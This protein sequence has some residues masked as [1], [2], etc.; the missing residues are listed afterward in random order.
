MTESLAIDSDLRE[1]VTVEVLDETF[2]DGQEATKDGPDK[3]AVANHC[4][5]GF[6]ERNEQGAKTDGTERSGH[7]SLEGGQRGVCGHASR[8]QEIPRGEDSSGGDVN[9]VLDDLSGPV[10][11]EQKVRDHQP[12]PLAGENKNREEESS[13]P[14]ERPKDHGKQ[15]SHRD[16]DGVGELV[17]N[18]SDALKDVLRE[19]DSVAP[20]VEEEH[21]DGG[22]DQKDNAGSNGPGNEPNDGRDDVATKSEAEGE[23]HNHAGKL[24]EQEDPEGGEQRPEDG[25][26]N[27][28]HDERPHGRFRTSTASSALGLLQLAIGVVVSIDRAQALEFS[29][30]HSEKDNRHQEMSE[31]EDQ[32]VDVTILSKC[33]ESFLFGSSASR[34][35]GDAFIELSGSVEAVGLFLELCHIAGLLL[36]RLAIGWLGLP[37]RLQW[38]LAIG[39]LLVGSRR[40]IGLGRLAV[41]LLLL[42][43]WRRGEGMW[44]LDEGIEL[45]RGRCTGPGRALVEA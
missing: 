41:G 31:E 11:G 19:L 29:V 38:R 8:R 4:S 39:L 25:A 30:A 13:G 21:V 43:L 2:K 35:D 26:Q 33:R 22:E 40:A 6:D 14:K 17:H 9:R 20:Q 10:E 37:V 12:L 36:R 15:G 5:E 1:C 18:L 44:S 28:G 24:A 42:L 16:P 45:D 7:G 23:V 3:A 34:T 32:E 27:D